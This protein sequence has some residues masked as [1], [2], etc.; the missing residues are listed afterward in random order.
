MAQGFLAD[1]LVISIGLKNKEPED[2]GSVDAGSVAEHAHLLGLLVRTFFIGGFT[3]V[4]SLPLS[5]NPC[6]WP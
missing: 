2:S 6:L 5:L 3:P 1:Y 4:S